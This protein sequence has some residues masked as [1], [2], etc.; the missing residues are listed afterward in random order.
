[1]PLKTIMKDAENECVLF[2][3][4]EEEDL[5]QKEKSNI[6][7]RKSSTDMKLAIAIILLEFA[8]VAICVFAR[9][10]RMVL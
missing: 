9:L 5:S 1:M 8:M 2:A 3:I 4:E 10:F 6:L 7:R